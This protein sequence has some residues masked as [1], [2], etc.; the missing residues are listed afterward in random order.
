MDDQNIQIQEF[1]GSTKGTTI[2]NLE[3][4][5]YTVNEIIHPQPPVD[6]LSVNAG[7]AQD[8]VQNAGFDNGGELFNSTSNTVYIICLEY[9]DEQGNDCNTITLAA[10]E[11]R[12]CTVKNYIR[13]SNDFPPNTD[14]SSFDI[15][16]SK[17]IA[18]SFYSPPTISQGT[19]EDLSALEKVEKLKAQWMELYQ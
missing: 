6:R 13:A 18:P 16:T 2:Q 1:E 19:E 9:E 10:G 8:C 17:G 7:I 15:S 12:T 5:T 3:P 11:E 4:G 14:T